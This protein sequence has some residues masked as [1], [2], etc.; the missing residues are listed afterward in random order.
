MGTVGGITA[1]AN[2]DCG[3]N[4]SL[5]QWGLWVEPEPGPMGTAGGITAWANGDCVWNHSLG[6]W[7]NITS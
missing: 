4:H 6:Q 1:W 5:G 2:G 7:G 3:W